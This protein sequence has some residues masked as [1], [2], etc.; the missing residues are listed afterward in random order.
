M[1]HESLSSGGVSAADTMTAAEHLNELRS[2]LIICCLALAAG[3]AVSFIFIKEIIAFLTAPVGHL[4]F[5]RPAEVLLIYT[6]T[7]FISGMI[8]SLPVF[9]YELWRFL[10]SALTAEERKCTVHLIPLVCL[11]FLLG[12]SFSFFCIVP[13]SLQFLAAFGGTVLQ[14]LF[15]MES[16]VDFIFAMTLPFGLIFQIPIVM[17]FSV[18]MGWIEPSHLQGKRKY[19]IITALIL[20]ALITPTPD[21]LSQLFMACP[22]ILLYE[23]SCFIIIRSSREK[24][25]PSKKISG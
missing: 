25:L 16:Y 3:T 8:L 10:R 19:V 4:Y 7:A 15:S 17:V 18:K 1:N 22:M 20:S 13:Q 9:L 14:P 11:L 5:I 12:T 23:I 24:E 6:K 2:R 21:I